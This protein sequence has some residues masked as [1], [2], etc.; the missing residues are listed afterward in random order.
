M[1][2]L[3]Q[4][5]AVCVS[6]IVKNRGA[7][8][9]SCNDVWMIKAI[10]Y[11]SSPV[12]SLS[13][14]FIILKPVLRSSQNDWPQNHHLPFWKTT[15]IHSHIIWTMSTLSNIWPRKMSPLWQ[16]DRANV[17]QFSRNILYVS[18]CLTG[19]CR[20]WWCVIWKSEEMSKVWTAFVYVCLTSGQL[21]RQ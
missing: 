21:I 17:T 16:H 8:C 19:I 6:T 12:L 5:T 14:L 7:L 20:N 9:T 2:R 11:C 3:S 1:K 15:K 4:T 13:V 10:T 18:L